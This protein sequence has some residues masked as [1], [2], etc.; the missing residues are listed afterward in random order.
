VANGGKYFGRAGEVPYSTAKE[1][2]AEHIKKKQVAEAEIAT[3]GDLFSAV[4]I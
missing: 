3:V 2:F 1:H 4:L